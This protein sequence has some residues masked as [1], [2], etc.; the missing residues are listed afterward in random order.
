MGSIADTD[1]AH[2]DDCGYCALLL[3]S[4]ASGVAQQTP[5]ISGGVGFFTSTTNGQ[6]SY[7]PIVE[8]LLAAPIGSRLLI[9]SRA[10]LLESFFPKGNGEAGYDHVH[11]VSLTYLQGDFLASPHVTVVGGSFLLPFNTY[12]ER[13]SPIWISNLQDGPLISTS[14]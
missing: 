12:N 1:K 9:E 14:A 8:P 5:L 13:L 3:Y 7:L 2:C 4:T 11:S 10:A 6:T